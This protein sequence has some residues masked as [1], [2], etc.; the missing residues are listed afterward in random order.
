VV[1]MAWLRPAAGTLNAARR[2][3]GNLWTLV[4]DARGRAHA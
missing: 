2:P 1:I 3:Y 4:A